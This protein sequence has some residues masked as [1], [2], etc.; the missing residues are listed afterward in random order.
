MTP[1]RAMRSVWAPRTIAFAYTTDAR[2]RAPCLRPASLGCSLL[3][4]NVQGDV[5]RERDGET[6]L[7]PG[8]RWLM[9]ATRSRRLM[10]ARYERAR[11]GISSLSALCRGLLGIGA[12]H[13]E[14]EKR[15]R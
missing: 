1:S 13:L 3:H 12:R 7:A 10:G 4:T 14:L 5:L 15:E 2:R 11:F 8:R 6:D 9:V